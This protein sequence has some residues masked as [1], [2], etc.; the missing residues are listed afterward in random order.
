MGIE[1]Q[2]LDGEN[3]T[4][5]ISIRLSTHLFGQKP[6]HRRSASSGLVWSLLSHPFWEINNSSSV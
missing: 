4:Q 5:C 3:L 6:L 2:E 1:L